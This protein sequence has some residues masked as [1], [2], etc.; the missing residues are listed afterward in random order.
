MDMFLACFVKSTS[1][2]PPCDYYYFWLTTNII[3]PINN[4]SFF[5]EIYNIINGFM[6]YL[7]V[8]K[9]TEQLQYSVKVPNSKRECSKLH[10][11]LLILLFWLQ[12]YLNVTLL[13]K[14][15]LNQF[16]TFFKLGLQL[17]NEILP[18]MPVFVLTKPEKY[19]FPTQFIKPGG[20]KICS[21][22]VLRIRLLHLRSMFKKISDLPW[23]KKKHVT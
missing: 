22:L 14:I 18:W 9:I 8:Q 11:Q 17:I 5:K 19:P 10:I 3:L 6:L 4:K 15:T 12:Q 20:A 16:H 13:S 21:F 23:D 1:C 2:H 7:S